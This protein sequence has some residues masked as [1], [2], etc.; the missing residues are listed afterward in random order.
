MQIIY[1]FFPPG[2]QMSLETI[3]KF[4]VVIF[5]LYLG[6]QLILKHSPYG[7]SPNSNTITTASTD[8]FSNYTPAN[9]HGGGPG[10]A[11]IPD[12]V[13]MPILEA[14]R[15]VLGGGPSPPSQ[16]APPNTV[17]VAQAQPDAQDPYA[18]G[19]EDA[20]ARENL[21]HP[22][23]MFR[24]APPMDVVDTITD[25]GLG[26]P[27]NQA[28]S[29]AMQTFMPEFAQNNGQFMDGIFAND[30]SEPTNFSMF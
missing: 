18:E 8:A 12:N 16:A 4:L 6:Y 11:D 20:N 30:T 22:E 17:R 25:A 26:G 28:T 7:K 19:N 21:R 5:I 13:P 24:P 29:N 3:L 14:P 2:F 1:L 27:A 10:A 15:N 23:R 9:T